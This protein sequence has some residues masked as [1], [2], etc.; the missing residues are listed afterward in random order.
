MSI[1]YRK[2]DQPDEFERI[3]IPVIK[4]DK[5][6]QGDKGET[7]E[8]GDRGER[9]VYVGDDLSSFSEEQLPDLWLQPIFGETDDIIQLEDVY[10]KEEVDVMLNEIKSGI[11]DSH[12]HKNFNVL[13][14]LNVSGDMLTFKGLPVVTGDGFDIERE[15]DELETN[16]KTIYGAINEIDREA[17]RST[18]YTDDYHQGILPGIDQRM[19]M[20]EGQF[21]T[22]TDEFVDLKDYVTRTGGKGNGTGSNEARDIIIL[23][24]GGYYVGVTVESALQEAGSAQ[25]KLKTQMDEIAKEYTSLNGSL[26][27]LKGKHQDLEGSIAEVDQKIA[28]VREDMGGVLESTKQMTVMVS[29][30]V[31]RV[32]DYEANAVTQNDFDQWAEENG[33][34]ITELKQKTVLLDNSIT[35]STQNWQMSIDATNHYTYR[36][37]DLID[38]LMLENELLKSRV[39]ALETG[40]SYVPVADITLSHTDE[41]LLVGETIQLSTTILPSNATNKN[42]TWHIGLPPEETDTQGIPLDAVTVTEDGLVQAI[43]PGGAIVYAMTEDGNK[44]ASCN[45]TIITGAGPEA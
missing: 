9:G 24:A 30:V 37:K 33:E 25:K 45:F 36:L 27:S 12:A 32:N 43:R 39:T 1:F 28:I 4:G 10:L 41:Y 5:G 2:P 31:D 29:S 23:D 34:V 11:G 18:D 13:E 3:R 16:E 14:E 42:V 19:D 7:G 8:K 35:N 44:T 38:K 21:I 6:D 26:E 22:L 15:F 40:G 20:L 17:I